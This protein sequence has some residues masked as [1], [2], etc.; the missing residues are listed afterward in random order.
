MYWHADNPP[1]CPIPRANSTQSSFLLVFG[2]S[3]LQEIAKIEL[4]Y[5]K[6]IHKHDIQ[7]FSVY[8]FLPYNLPLKM[9]KSST[10]NLADNS[11]LGYN[12]KITHIHYE[13]MRCS[14]NVKFKW[15]TNNFF[16]TSKSVTTNHLALKTSFSRTQLNFVYILINCKL[17]FIF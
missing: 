14:F 15:V 7:R 11:V 8:F 13:I 4:L 10:S 16:W 3:L 5:E 6:S 1:I 9:C 12:L 2:F 17:V